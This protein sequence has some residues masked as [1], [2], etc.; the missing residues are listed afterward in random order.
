MSAAGL[1]SLSILCLL[2]TSTSYYVE[3]QSVQ[4]PLKNIRQSIN[5]NRF[6]ASEQNLTI[7]KCE[8]VSDQT[9]VI[10]IPNLGIVPPPNPYPGFIESVLVTCINLASNEIFQVVPGSFDLLPNLSYL[11]LS[12]NRIQFCDFFNF[13]SSNT[14]LVTL[15]IE[16][17]K[18]PIDNIDKTIGKANCFPQLRYLYLRKN[19][20]RSL[21]FS[22][23]KA[24]P[25]LTH[26]FLSDN[27]V[28]T[29]NFIR[30][31]PR[32]LS[33]LYL[34]RNLISS[35]DCK[36]MRGLQYLHLDGNIIQTICY[37]NCQ[38]TSLKLEGVHK[39]STL[40]I[41]QNR[42]LDIESCAFQD[43]LELMNINLAQN[44]LEDIKHDTFEKLV[45]LRQLNI[46]DNYLRTIPNLCR[47]NNLINLSLKRNKLQIIKRQHFKNLR[48]LKCL[49]L[50]GNEINIIEAGSFED[51][52]SLE[53]LDLSN[54]GLDFI[55]PDWL[56]WQLN[57]R[58]LDIR[59]NKFKSLEQLSIVTAPFLN[60]IYLQNNAITHISGSIVSKF[61]PHVMIYLQN[62]CS[63]EKY[64]Q[65]NCYVTC[66]DKIIKD[67][68]AYSKWINNV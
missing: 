53:E 40:T 10:N 41:S 23:K 18:P 1:L 42:I 45:L 56:K 44:N 67:A 2:K 43:A 17:N 26:L 13:G 25:L 33:H 11:D 35:L 20:I 39:L 51:L 57:L 28:D 60:V 15:I 12:K 38:D 63:N 31:L 32:T 54:N 29:Q 50:G 21:N 3:S 16:E 52:E 48:K 36:I 37:N 62:D 6:A 61:S 34:E 58:T 65:S 27:N 7:G 46:D 30:D 59:G 68:N 19:N 4:F 22:L 66:N 24:F 8:H 55:P 47:N 64:N 5:L 9:I 49:L 14:R